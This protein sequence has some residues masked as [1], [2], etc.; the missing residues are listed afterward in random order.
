MSSYAATN[1][2]K[3]S[4]VFAGVSVQTKSQSTPG[5]TAVKIINDF[6]LRQ[7]SQSLA[8]SRIVFIAK[9]K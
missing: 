2:G 9:L 6:I 8:K 5:L 7:N 3:E 1:Q 4:L